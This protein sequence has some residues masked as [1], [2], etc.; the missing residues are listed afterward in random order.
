MSWTFVGREPELAALAAALDR[1]REGLGQL[2]V[3]RGE[4]GIGK[5]TLV[6]RFCATAS[7]VGVLWGSC[8][9][10][11]GEPTYWPWVQVLRGAAGAGGDEV[12]NRLAD[13]LAPLG[14]HASPS[15][16]TGTMVERFALFDAVTQVLHAL[17]GTRPLVVVL[18]NLHAGG[19]ANALMLE[20]VARHSRHVAML[21]IA[22]YREVDARLDEDLARV[23]PSLEAAATTITV[24]AFTD[25]DVRDLA[26]AVLPD[27]PDRLIA[28]VLDRTQ[29][30][31]LFVAQVL[32]HLKR[33]DDGAAGRAGEPVPAALRLAI[34]RRAARVAGAAQVPRFLDVAAVLGDQVDLAVVAAVLGQPVPAVASA[35]DLAVDAGIMRPAGPDYAFVHALMREAIYGDLQ[36]AVRRGWHL[37]VAHE[38]AARD[39]HPALVAHHYLAA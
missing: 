18:E 36:P 31:P 14:L 20:F 9:D 16:E 22:T 5:T 25:G 39:A 33:H 17:A 21:L 1:V 38:L 19:P 24:P 3:V 2:I 30:N 34:Q 28:E 29:G 4:P 13:R 15:A 27:P 26:A 7:R 6:E 37:A 8:W 23:I 11:V 32:D 10:G 12:V 35:A